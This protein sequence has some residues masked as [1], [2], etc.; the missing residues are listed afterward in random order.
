MVGWR[1]RV[2]KPPIERRRTA[3]S[4]PNLCRGYIVLLGHGGISS[5]KH[6][7][8]PKFRFMFGLV[9]SFQWLGR[10][11]T[12]NL[13]QRR[14]GAKAQRFD[15]CAVIPDFYP[16]IPAKAGIQRVVGRYLRA[17]SPQISD[18]H[19]LKRAVSTRPSLLAARARRR[20][21]RAAVETRN[22]GGGCGAR[23]AFPTLA[24]IASSRP[25]R[26]CVKF[27]VSARPSN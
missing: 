4:A 10:V 5:L 26:H 3:K 9:V 20:Y 7:S 14:E 23:T 21:R 12:R 17:P 6:M 2:A 16:V 25:S 11:D 18:L 13:T 27:P 22:P 1:G 24:I 8:I 15:Y 19:S